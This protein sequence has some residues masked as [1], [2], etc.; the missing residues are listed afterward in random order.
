MDRSK[1]KRIGYIDRMKFNALPIKER[2]P[3]G[4]YLKNKNE[5]YIEGWDIC[6]EKHKMTPI[7]QKQGKVLN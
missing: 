1:Q 4:Y 6:G 5:S 7:N 3:L 2:F